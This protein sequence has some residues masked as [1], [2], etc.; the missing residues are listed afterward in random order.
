MENTIYN[1]VRKFQSGDRDCGLLLVEQFLPI[2]K[3]YAY[4]LETEDAVSEMQEAFL[5]I[6]K[7]IN[8]SRMKNTSDGGFVTYFNISMNRAYKKFSRRNQRE[9]MMFT[10]IESLNESEQRQIEFELSALDN[11]DRIFLKEFQSCLTM[12]E[13]NL[14]ILMFGYGLSAAEV[15]KIQGITRQT[16]NEM[17][18]NALHKIK[19]KIM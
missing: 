12:K 16:A 4:W 9:Q 5:K 1:L 15:A 17:K 6:L 2:I 11:H 8:L 7:G 10:N 14:I 3:K 19:K 13:F 18:K